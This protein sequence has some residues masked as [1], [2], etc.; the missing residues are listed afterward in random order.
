MK[1][2][3][4][5]LFLSLAIVSCEKEPLVDTSLNDIDDVNSIAT[6]EQVISQGV[7][8]V[9]FHA[10]WCEKC[11]E[12][13]PAVESCSSDPSLTFVKFFEVE[14]EDN[15]EIVKQYDIPG[16]PTMVIYQNGE[17]VERFV[18]KGHSVEQ[19]TDALIKL[20]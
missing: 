15:K 18:G 5:I 11:E 7:S 3:F 10:S 14:Y 20:K 17:E 19:F 13:R 16:F 2:L 4:L 6:F 9:F 12:Q 8:F 1:N